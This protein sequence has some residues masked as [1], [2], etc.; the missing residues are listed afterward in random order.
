[1]RRLLISRIEAIL[2]YLDRIEKGR[3][4]LARLT[5]YPALALVLFREKIDP[6]RLVVD[7]IP[8]HQDLLFEQI[9]PVLLM[10]HPGGGYS[11]NYPPDGQASEFILQRGGQGG[12]Y[13]WEA[14]VRCVL[15]MSD[16]D[17]TP[18]V[19]DPEADMLAV[20]GPNPD[21]LRKIARIIIDMNAN[22]EILDQAIAYAE[23]N[24]FLE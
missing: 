13:S 7:P 6:Y 20:Y 5:V 19:F 23:E 15:E 8:E 14:L 18:L 16:V 22:H 9:G 1:M 4:R 17:P 12:G 2:L 10:E 24:G 3:P 11:L 21:A